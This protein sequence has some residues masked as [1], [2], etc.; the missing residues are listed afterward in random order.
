MNE[1]GE[2][3]H[4]ID[5]EQSITELMK[6]FGGFHDGCVREIHVQSGTYVD[7]NRALHPAWHIDVTF[8]VQRQWPNPSAIEMK[9]EN[10]ARMNIAPEKENYDPW[11]FGASLHMFD[12]L[13]FWSEIEEFNPM[14][15]CIGRIWISAKKAYWRDVSG[16]MGNK[17]RY[18][19]TSVS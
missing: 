14:D 19:Q 2:V 9:F 3:W 8:F 13:I 4:A 6:L 10:V 1:I 7:E 17:I 16:W 11:I 15:P 5:S 12:G 18:R